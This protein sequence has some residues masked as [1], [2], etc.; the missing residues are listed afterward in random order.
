MSWPFLALYAVVRGIIFSS[1]LLLVGSQMAVRL[2]TAQLYAHPD[3][4][5]PLH[6]R[7]RLMSRWIVVVLGVAICLKG[8]PV[9]GI[10]AARS[11]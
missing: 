3:F 4:G 11:R 5:Q 1:I 2:I 6:A 7:L 10:V 8:A 9:L